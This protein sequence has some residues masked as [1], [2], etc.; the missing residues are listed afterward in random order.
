MEGE[1]LKRIEFEFEC[2]TLDKQILR[3]LI[4]DEVIQINSREATE[5]YKELQ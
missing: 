5:Y 4:L 2:F 3:E 1:P